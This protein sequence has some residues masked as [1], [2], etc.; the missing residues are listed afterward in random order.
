[1]PRKKPPEGEAAGQDKMEMTSI[2]LQRVSGL[3]HCRKIRC[4]V[5]VPALLPRSNCAP[6]LT[7]LE[8]CPNQTTRQIFYHY[9]HGGE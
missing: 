6:I 2:Y 3:T 8:V 1:M 4:P 5:R 7:F 9:P